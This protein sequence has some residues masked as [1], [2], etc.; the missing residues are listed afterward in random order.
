MS[1]THFADN[2]RDSP[3]ILR[4]THAFTS[5]LTS[6]IFQS[7]LEGFTNWYFPRLLKAH[8]LLP[9][10]RLLNLT[11]FPPIDSN[12][13]TFLEYSGKFFLSWNSGLWSNNLID[14]KCSGCC[15]GNGGWQSHC[16]QLYPPASCPGLLW[17]A[18][19]TTHCEYCS[20]DQVAWWKRKRRRSSSLCVTMKDIL[21]Y[22][23]CRSLGDPPEN[24]HLNVKKLPKSWIFWKNDNFWHFI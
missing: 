20:R 19:N 11:W 7:R 17:P 21:W 1:R 2:S 9:S 15:R 12:L 4:V 8:L 24:C 22:V 23:L 14:V 16:V 10:R 18:V 5:S 13:W 6:Q 3:L